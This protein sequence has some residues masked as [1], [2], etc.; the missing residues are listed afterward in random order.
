MEKQAIEKR[1]QDLAELKDAYYEHG[2]DTSKIVSEIEQLRSELAA[3]PQM[4]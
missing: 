3:I 1:L 4:E 2:K